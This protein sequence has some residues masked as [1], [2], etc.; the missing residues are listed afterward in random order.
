MDG[1]AVRAQDTDLAGKGQ[2]DQDPCDT[3]DISPPIEGPWLTIVETVAAGQTPQIELQAGQAT[4]IMT[5]A[6][7]P[8]GADSVVMQERTRSEAGRVQIHEAAKAGQHV[9]YAGEDVQLD[10][11]VLHQGQTIR[12]ASVG[13]A[14]AV[15]RTHLKVFKQPTV[16][17]IST[18][19]EIVL[20]GLPLGPGQIY[21]S[22]TPALMGLVREAGAIPIDCGIARDDLAATRKAFETAAKCDLI[23]STG[24][25]SVGDF[26]VVKEAM[27]GL[28]AEMQFWKVRMKPGKP[29]ALGLI[30]QTPAFGLPGNPV[31]CQVG[32]LQFVRPWIRTAMGD[33]KPFL[34]VIQAR[35]AVPYSKRAGRCEFVRVTLHVEDGMWVANLSGHQGSGNQ[36]SMESAHGLMLLSN[37]E[38]TLSAGESVPVQL[39]G[40]PPGQSNDGYPWE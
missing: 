35:L 13:L 20:P 24:G 2:A 25:V 28:G 8:K 37:S 23:V 11:I 40:N 39:L 26:D 22:N 16:G 30:K 27:S 7:M 18:G 17:I 3:R 10:A 32:F 12:P 1:F 5:G 19:D 33:T 36:T 15:G 34:P 4:R 14:A 6:P 21:S 38:H 31:S 29:L 9:R